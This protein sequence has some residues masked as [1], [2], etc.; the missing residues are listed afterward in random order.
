MNVITLSGYSATADVKRLELGTFDSFGIEQLQVIKGDGWED[1]N[2]IVTF[3][4]PN[5]GKAVSVV[6]SGTDTKITFNVPPQATAKNYG[7][8]K[9]VFVGKKDGVQRISCDLDY[10]VRMHSNCEGESP[11][12]PSPDVVSQILEIAEAAKNTADST[13][14]DSNDYKKL[15]DKKIQTIIVAIQKMGGDVTGEEPD[16]TWLL[17]N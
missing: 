3:N 13:K 12:T 14:S 15:T 16:E 7:K 10:Y 1:L 9:I 2:V 11:T 4:P 5:K 6:F 17:T 8:G